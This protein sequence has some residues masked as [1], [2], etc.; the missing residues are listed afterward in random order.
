MVSAVDIHIQTPAPPPE[1]AMSGCG[2][3]DLA[4]KSF[5]LKQELME[6][7]RFSRNEPN[8]C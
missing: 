6:D 4:T 1:M 8:Y 2:K 3:M 7:P 5:H